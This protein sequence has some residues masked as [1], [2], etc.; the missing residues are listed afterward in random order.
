MNN[1][2][3]LFSDLNLDS[4]WLQAIDDMGFKHPTPIQKLA[5]PKILDG[6]DLLA[7]AQ[8]GTGKTAAFILPVLQ[9][10][11]SA[12]N[13]NG[14]HTLILVPTRELALQIDQQIMGLSY[15]GSLSSMS[16]YGG[17]DGVGWEQ[18]KSALKA[19]VDILVAT[20]GKL[21]SHINM[22]N[23]NLKTIRTLVLDEADRMLDMGF[24]DDLNK[25]V[26][27]TNPQR[28]T[29]MF[30]A[31]MPEKIRKLAH[32]ILTNP[33]QINL[34]VSK[35]AEKVSQKLVLC[36]EEKKTAILVHLLNSQTYQSVLIFA[37]TKSKV[38]QI[39]KELHRKG[40]KI[41]AIHSDLDQNEREQ[42]LLEFKSLKLPV[43]VATDVISRGIDIDTIELVINVDV[44]ADAEDYIHR[45]G[46]TARASR[47]GE[48]I[49]LAAPLDFRKV[50]RIERLIEKQIDRIDLPE[51]PFGP[52]P[53]FKVDDFKHKPA[54]ASGKPNSFKKKS[55][56]KRRNTSNQPKTET[57]KA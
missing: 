57:P 34:A 26:K 15:Y 31:T 48:A 50:Q 7:C 11:N 30:S 42:V 3:N 22:G 12:E 25:I 8:T 56:F 21:I 17:G 27:E 5:I 47:N 53:E 6:K 35:P 55:H 45:V 46:R 38:K 49:T 23:V 37:S 54:N 40:I 36:Y 10:A 1:E 52:F 9:K 51:T 24:I 20:P 39:E 4:T 18:Q 28:Q 13:V 44:P 2:I 16:M 43:L 14:I 33:E 32:Q 19:G 41:K 29:L